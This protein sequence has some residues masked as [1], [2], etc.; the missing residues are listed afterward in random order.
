MMC[1]STSSIGKLS[2][3]C[4]TEQEVTWIIVGEHKD[5]AIIDASICTRDMESV[6]AVNNRAV[7]LG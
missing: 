3:H 6:G 1:R 7:G 5:Y 2:D 4:N